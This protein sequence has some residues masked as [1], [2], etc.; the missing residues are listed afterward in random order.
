MWKRA[1]IA[2]L[3]ILSLVGC[4]PGQRGTIDH[5]DLRAIVER[6]LIRFGDDLPEAMIDRLADHRILVVGE[7]HDISE[8]DAF[9]GDLVVALQPRGLTTVLLEFPQAYSWLLDAYARGVTDTPG[10]GATRTYGPLLD[11]IRAANAALPPERQIAVRAIDVNPTQGEFL[12]PFRG[13]AH[14]L[15][16]P[17][18]LVDLVAALEGGADP[19]TA[20]AAAQAELRE[21]E[22]VYRACWGDL[23]YTVL[24]DA[25]DGEARSAVVRRVGEGAA[26]DEA[27]EIAMHALVDRQLAIAPGTALVNVGYFHGQK[28]RQ[29]G[30]VD[31][32]LAQRLVEEGSGERGDTYVLVVVPASGEKRIRGRVRPFDVGHESPQNEL[33]RVMQGVAGGV[34]AFLPLDDEVFRSERIVVNYLPELIVGPPRDAFDAFVLLPE[35]RYV[36]R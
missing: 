34:P 11:R 17:E 4:L 19:D 25:L 3:S 24:L 28:R 32:W 29:A 7:F 26:R 36:G 5:D 2:L 23:G 31:R 1:L 22:A 8:H 35:V 12:P 20:L 14:A 9:V 6:D 15:G 21:D 16:Q 13:L 30:T 10:E 33:F 18:V 27:R